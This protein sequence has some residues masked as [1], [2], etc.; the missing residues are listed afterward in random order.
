MR[1][2]L[3]GPAEGDDEVLRTALE[4][5]VFEA[6]V[7]QTIYLGVD[8][9][10]GRVIAQWTRDLAGSDDATDAFLNDAAALACG[11]DAASIERLLITEAS[12]QRLSSVQRLPRP[13]ARA[14]ELL[15]HRIVMLVYDK[16]VLD[17]EDILNAY[18][19]VYGKSDEALLKRFGPR[20]FFTPGPLKKRKVAVLELDDVGQITMS[21]FAP[22]GMVLSKEVLQQQ[23]GARLSVAQ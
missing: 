2:G 17:E 4:F 20:Y 6:K 22:T 9:G 13:P 7:D 11:G 12:A 5:L 15:E 10:V 23:L 14:I 1:I 18:M 3:V 19:L 21:M 16:A 8:G